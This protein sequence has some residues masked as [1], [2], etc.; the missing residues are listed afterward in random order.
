M[1]V[2]RLVFN[3]PTANYRKPFS[4]ANVLHSFPL[5]PPSTVL[6][7]IHNVCGLKDGEVIPNL[8]LAIY[9]KY[10][11]VTYHY[12]QLRNL[13]K[14]G[15]EK[16][17]PAGRHPGGT[18]P[19]RVQL[20]VNVNLIIYIRTTEVKEED[21]NR[22]KE[23]CGDKLHFKTLTEIKNCFDNPSAPFIIGR[24]EDLA[25]L[26]D[27]PEIIRI[28][29]SDNL[30]LRLEVPCWFRIDKKSNHNEVNLQGIPYLLNTY[31]K[32]VR[33]KV[34]QEEYE[35]RDFSKIRCIY[36]EEQELGV[37]FQNGKYCIPKGYI[38]TDY[39]L[40]LFFLN[41]SEVSNE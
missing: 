13:Y 3:Q 18:M 39:N 11:S 6:G 33:I 25:I 14:P 5:P 34:E 8:D 28:N 22:F 27:K 32:K 19:V 24:R 41:I 38:D 26:C 7:M 9:G 1:E 17:R 37:I 15:S 12:Q 29:S 21:K 10:E 20:L 30:T 36:A 31:Y 16:G 2:L 40:P 4:Q 23:M 35:I